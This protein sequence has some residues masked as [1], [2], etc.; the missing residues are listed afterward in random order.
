MLSDYYR[1]AKKK[2]DPVNGG[3]IFLAKCSGKQLHCVL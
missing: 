1:Q 2:A 3:E